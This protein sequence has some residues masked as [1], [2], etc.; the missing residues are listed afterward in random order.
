LNSEDT[1]HAL[2]IIREREREKL[3]LMGDF[4]TQ[5]DPTKVYESRKKRANAKDLWAFEM[6]SLLGTQ[7]FDAL[8]R[9]EAQMEVE[10][11][12]RHTKSKD[13]NLD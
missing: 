5:A 10:L 8:S 12:T 3:A 1:E 13:S 7:R 2:E 11:K 4:V 6:V 9:A